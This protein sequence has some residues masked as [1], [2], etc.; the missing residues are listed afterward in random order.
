MH[1]NRLLDLLKVLNKKEVQKLYDYID[2]P[3]FAKSEDCVR[4]F[5]LIKPYFG[6]W[7]SPNWKKEK[8]F[9]KIFP[10]TDYTSARFNK[11]CFDAL[12]LVEKCYIF[13]HLNEEDVT[14]YDDL[15]NLYVAE[16]LPRLHESLM[17]S[18]RNNLEKQP[19]RNVSYLYQSFLLANKTAQFTVGFKED[20]IEKDSEYYISYADALDAFY[21]GKKLEITCSAINIQKMDSNY[22][23]READEAEEIITFFE[24]HPHLLENHPY[25]QTYYHAF[26]LIKEIDTFKHVSKLVDLLIEY[27]T[28][29]TKYDLLNLYAYIQNFYIE[30]INLG[31]ANF[32]KDLF[33]T[34]KHLTRIGLL[35]NYKGN[36]I[37]SVFK[38]IV[39]LALRLGEVDWTREFIELQANFLPEEVREDVKNYCLALLAFKEKEYAKTLRYLHSLEPADLFFNLSVRRLQ[40]QTYFEQQDWEVMQSAINTFRVF[41][42]RE[43]LLSEK[44]KESYR[45]FCTYTLKAAD[46]FYEPQKLEALQ[47]EL[48]KISIMTEKKWLLTKVENWVKAKIK[49]A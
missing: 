44:Q 26:L 35:E 7:D 24:K 28:I 46:I 41:I 5:T 25:I 18:L 32:E 33:Y 9:A 13:Y 14:H 42:H 38:N 21:W 4:F 27:E 22:A 47:M 6:K 34:Y 12:D 16:R 30:Q 1:D 11:L 17:K 40:I 43:K 37:I 31:N 39:L 19:L 48:Q 36:F 20:R 23:K 3:F 10:K 15:L 2:S 49:Q 8:I 29:F 45:N